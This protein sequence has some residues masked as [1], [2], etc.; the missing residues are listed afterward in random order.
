MAGEVP[1]A[2][3]RYFD[4]LN[5]ENWDDFNGIWTEDAE[6]IG[7]GARPRS[8]KEDVLTYYS[9]VLV[10]YPVHYDDP[11]AIHVAGDIVTVEIH[12]T[13]ETHEGVPVE[14]EAVDVFTMRDGMICRLTTW[15]DI[16][17]V[18]KAATRPGAPGTR[19]KTLV[20]HAAK[21]SPFY[22]ERFA[23]AGVAAEGVAADITTLPPTRPAALAGAELAAVDAKHVAQEITLGGFTLP[24]V[25]TDVAEND[26]TLAKALETAGVTAA[27][28]ILALASRRGLAAA[29]AHL[30]ATMI[31][32][33]GADP[34][35][36][37][38]E[39]K[40]TVLFAPAHADVAGFRAQAEAS[41][42]DLSSV[43]LVVGTTHN[44]G[45]WP[46]AALWGTPATGAV[47]AACAPGSAA[48]HVF[49]RH[50]IEVVDENGSPVADGV[51]GEILVTPLGRRGAP[52]LRF[53]PGARG[54][55]SHAPCSCGRSGPLLRVS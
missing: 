17:A 32:P 30:R 29:A 35:A 13:G 8:G 50:L 43:R 39:G 22:R 31:V 9:T 21:R 23:A 25:A 28:R 38:A 16:D 18:R 4:G 46:H 19:L 37:A 51:E 42:A 3:R 33:G 14:F 6:L 36:A 54:S 53:A 15:Y 34:V 41:G 45:G 20:R 49:D 11:Y 2:I 1:E 7:V 48:L 44:A 10:P 24:L 47:A 26:E 40:A 52:L 12:F 27:D 5:N 55:L